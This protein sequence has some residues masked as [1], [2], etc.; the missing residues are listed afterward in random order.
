MCRVPCATLFLKSLQRICETGSIRL[1]FLQPLSLVLGCYLS[2]L[3][4]DSRM[5]AKQNFAHV[6]TLIVGA[7]PAGSFLASNLARLGVEFRIIGI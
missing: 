3:P 4:V 7:G 2:A 1:F 6:T 5:I